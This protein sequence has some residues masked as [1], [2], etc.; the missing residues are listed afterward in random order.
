[1]L[2]ECI[3][4]QYFS[5]LPLE[6]ADVR[7]VTRYKDN[8]PVLGRINIQSTHGH[9]SVSAAVYI[10]ESGNPLMDMD[11]ISSLNLCIKGNTALTAKDSVLEVSNSTASFDCAKNFVH[12]VKL[13][14]DVASVQQKLHRLPFSVRDAVSTEL[15]RLLAAYIIER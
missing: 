12:K 8:L 1:M 5:D 13:C 10:V 2:P 11:Y 9:C 15:N 14:Q 7:F 3:Y 6:H 4:K